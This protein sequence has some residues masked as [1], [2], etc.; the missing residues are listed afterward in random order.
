MTAPTELPAVHVNW[1]GPFRAGLRRARAGARPREYGFPAEEILTCVHSALAWRQFHGP[2][3]LTTDALGA[4]WVREQGLDVLYDTVDTALDTLDDLDLNPVVYFTGGKYPAVRDRTAPFALLDTDLYLRRPLT[5]LD[6]GGF[7][8]AHWESVDNPVYPE[9]DTLPN[10][11]GADLS[12]WVFD[13]PA[14]NMAVAVFLDEHHRAAFAEAA[15]EYACGNG[16]PAP[17]EPVARPA[18]AEQ[19]LAPAVARALGVSL[20]PVA[21]GFWLVEEERWDGT[22]PTADFHHTWNLKAALRRDPDLRRAYLRL[23]LEE[24]LSRFPDSAQ[25]LY[26]VPALKPLAPLVVAVADGLDRHGPV[27]LGTF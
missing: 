13:T 26:G 5:G 23:L 3:H 4:A 1:T 27:G 17:G 21:S 25:L 2:V 15:L 24:L 7:R 8:F 11:A 16:G 12:R 18:F 14:T 6:Q 22:P 19:R 10:R 9:P 20:R